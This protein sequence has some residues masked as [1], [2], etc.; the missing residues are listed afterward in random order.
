MP[1]MSWHPWRAIRHLDDVT[2]RWERRDG[3]LGSWDAATRTMTF[4]PDQSQRQRRCTAAHEVVHV[5]RGDVGHCTPG[6]E[7]RVE[8]EAARRLVSLAALA[9]A[10]LWCVDEWELAEDL[11]VDQATV[12]ARLDSLT[13]WE[14]AYV[15]DRMAAKDEG[16]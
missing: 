9:D 7:R 13:A 5:E 3:L 14:Q 15:E 1:R 6:L 12:R 8:E 2:V 10:L 11:W 16:A 4:H